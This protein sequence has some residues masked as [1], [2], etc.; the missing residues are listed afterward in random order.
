MRPCSTTASTSATDRLPPPT[1]P[2]TPIDGTNLTSL[3][4]GGAL[5]VIAVSDRGTMF[6][7]GPCVYME[8]LAVGPKAAGSVDVRRPP[9]ENLEAVAK[10][11]GKSVPRRHRRHPRPAP[12]RR[13]HRGGA[14]Q[15]RPHQADLRRRRGRCH[16]GGVARLGGRRPVRHR[17]HPRGGDRGR[18]AQVHGWGDPGS[19]VPPRRRRTP[20]RPWQP[21]TTS[22]PCSAP[23]TS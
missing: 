4:R 10:A 16:L 23:T 8:K 3:G 18:G 15:R 17:G 20:G 5:A 19:P 2:S 13:S 22:T 7:P 21:A 11:L 1:S 14:R 9:T 6:N 12:A